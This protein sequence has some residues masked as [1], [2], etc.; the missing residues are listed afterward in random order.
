MI[1]EGTRIHVPSERT[2][3]RGLA[4]LLRRNPTDAE[5]ILWD[6][7]TRDRRFA[8]LSFKRQT[9]IGPVIADLVSFPLRAVIEVVPA[10]GKRGVGA[11]ARQQAALAGEHDY[12]VLQAGGGGSFGERFQCAGQTFCSIAAAQVDCEIC[13]MI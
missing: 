6:A 11:V 2:P 9:P 1:A 10:D 5:R 12:T 8:G 7:L 3:A 4:K 13:Q